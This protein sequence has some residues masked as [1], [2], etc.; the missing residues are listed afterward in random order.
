MTMNPEIIVLVG[1]PGSGKS[2][3]C[4]KYKTS[5]IRISQDEMGKKEHLVAFQIHLNRGDN[6]IIDRMGFSK[7]QRERYLKPAREAGYNTRIVVFHVPS[8]ICRERA[9]ARIPNHPTVL[10]EADAD[11]AIN[12]FFTKYER[13]EDNEADEVI[14]LGWDE[15]YKSEIII[16]DLDGTLAN[17]DH[18]LGFVKDKDVDSEET[19]KKDWKS[20]FKNIP[21][22]KVNEW[23]RQLI[24]SMY[25][26]SRADIV[27]CSGRPDDYRKD[28]Q[29]WLDDNGFDIGPLYMRRRGD[30][31]KDDV[32]KEIILDF[33]LLPRYNI[34]FAVD[35]RQQV[36]DKFRSRGII[37]LQC[38]KGD[39]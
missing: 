12:F 30:Y 1:P 31:R 36:V 33:E 38:Q 35:D 23:C 2:T 22:D 37:V 6:L 24:M 34:L 25:Y 9:V 3:Y 8:S 21:G 5:H 15:S 11:R 19:Q 7:E 10:T 20:F 17:I 26:D 29:Q 4:E 27:F 18:R 14:R 32:I 28:T 16:C 39:Y 13:V